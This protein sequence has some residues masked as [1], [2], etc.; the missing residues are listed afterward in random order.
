MKFE[1]KVYNLDLKYPFGISREIKSS[2]N[3]V[4]TKISY[5]YKGI[6]YSGYGEAA[7]SSFYGESTDTVIAYYKW[8]EDSKILE[9]TP[10]ELTDINLKLS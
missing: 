7:P 5:D 6:T 1:Y 9:K 2:V 10:Y 8:V 3:R 4:I